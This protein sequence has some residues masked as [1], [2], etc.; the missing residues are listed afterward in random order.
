MAVSIR[1]LDPECDREDLLAFLEEHL[2]TLPHARRFPWLYLANPA[3]R[4][5][6][7]AA[8]DSGS[9]QMV[10]MTALFPRSVWVDGKLEVC[11]Q[12]G[13]F[14]IAPTH[15]SLGPAVLIQRATFQ[16]VDNGT[17]RF[18]YDC[19]PHLAGM[20][21]F[22]RI[23]LGPSCEVHRYALPLRIEEHL[24]K[25]FRV[26]NPAVVAA[27]NALWRLARR[28]PSIPRGLDMADHEGRFGDEFTALDHR[29]KTAGAI[30]ASRGAAELNWRYRD[31]PLSSYRVLAARR[32]GELAGYL[33]FQVEPEQITIAD[34][35]STGEPDVAVAL[36]ESLIR[37]CA[38]GCHT[39][40]AYVSPGS[41]VVGPLLRSGFRMRGV[42]AHVVAYAP[43]E[44]GARTF[45]DTGARWKFARAEIS[46]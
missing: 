2:P 25:R 34:L 22:R 43:R 32:R 45:L 39:I 13:D 1:Q 11:G 35:F 17:L 46:A 26:A 12:V 38:H 42:A 8:V 30:R 31:D 19:P 40:A 36:L 41:D 9:G 7:W 27:A 28:G 23:G 20:S 37:R 4:A 6:S 21:T 5:W 14:A 24:K 33:A 15:R 29:V 18:C 3:G 44:T 10:G 16:P